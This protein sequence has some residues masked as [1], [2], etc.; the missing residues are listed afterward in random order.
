MKKIGN[1]T[2]NGYSNYGNRLQNYALQKT[3]ESLGFFVET[4]IIDNERSNKNLFIRLKE[5]KKD[6]IV[7]NTLNKIN[8][9]INRKEFA[10]STQIRTE[11]FKN[12]SKTHIKE[13]DFSISINSVPEKLSDEYDYFITGSDQVWNPYFPI[14]Q[15]LYFITFAPKN[16]RISYAPSFGISEL[17]DEVKPKYRKWLNEIEFLS[18]REN[19]GASIIKELTGRE[20]KVLVDP[21]LLLTKKEW[22][23]IASATTNNYDKK[24]LLT[25]FLGGIPRE[26]QKQITDIANN[27]DLQIINLGDIKEKD[28]YR[29]GPSEFIDYINKCSIF[30][31]D[32]FHGAVFAILLEKPFIVYER[33]GKTS[34]YSRL[35]TLLDKFELNSRKVENL[36]V[37]KDCFNIN[38]DHVSSILEDEKFK[39]LNFLRDALDV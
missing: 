16:K 34:M 11:I 37:D 13:T 19:D 5:N 35:N 15:E 39:A 4:I 20:S 38:F 10:Q 14:G 24:F 12:F 31:T 17:S 33:I 25:Y 22:I 7:K 8:N 18:V 27:H 30:C 28:T 21:T 3:L 23:E 6:K 2:L 29:T 1:I 32:S 36:D 9:F 26:F